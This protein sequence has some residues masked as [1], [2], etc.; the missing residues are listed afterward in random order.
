MAYLGKAGIY[1]TSFS[2]IKFLSSKAFHYEVSFPS[3]LLDYIKCIK[4][5]VPFKSGSMLDL[6]RLMDN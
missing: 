6:E 2:V 4:E 3:P 1:N 5:T